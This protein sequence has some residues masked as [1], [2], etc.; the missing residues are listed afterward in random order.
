MDLQHA[1]E[2]VAPLAV[3][4]TLR[5]LGVLVALWLSFAIAR[6]LQHKVTRGLRSRKFD[7]TLAIFFGNL[8]RWLILV[9]AVIA[10][11]GV[12][13]I[14]TT[15]FAAVLGAAGLAIGLAFQGTLSNFA[16]GVML[17]V[18]RP[19]KVGDYVVAGG[20]EGVVAEVGLFVTA[21]DTP[22]NRRLF[23]PNTAIGSGAI[24]NYSAHGIRRVDIPINIAASEDIDNTRKA[25]EAAAAAVPG[26]DTRNPDVFLK[27]FDAGM[28]MWQVRVWAPT[29]TYWDV[30]QATIRAIGYELTNAGIARPT[31]ALK[32]I[33]ANAPSAGEGAASSS[34]PPNRL[35]AAH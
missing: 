1:L 10:C 13:G 27:G 15:T 24:E 11:L 4:Y 21:I 19:F 23:V 25:L 34:I 30:W 31:P 5:I 6:W 32:V 17:L 14:Q 26:Q 28:V 33:V 29:A 8:L 35:P 3:T 18:F 12:F 9:A 20:K 2:S 16:A 7:E 22:D